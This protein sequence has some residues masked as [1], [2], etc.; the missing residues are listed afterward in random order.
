MGLYCVPFF[1]TERTAYINCYPGEQYVVPRHGEKKETSEEAEA[2][3]HPL[4]RGPRVKAV[5]TYAVHA[6]TLVG[7]ALMC[8]SILRLCPGK[9]VEDAR[10]FLYANGFHVVPDGGPATSSTWSPFSVAEKC[11]L[12]SG[13]QSELAVFRLTDGADSPHEKNH[14]FATE[15][16]EADQRRDSLVKEINKGIQKVTLSLFPV[17]EIKVAPVWG[18]V[19]TYNRI[20]AGY[21]LSLEEATVSLQYCDLCAHSQGHARLSIYD[22]EWCD[23]W[24]KYLSLT[25]RTVVSCRS[26]EHS[27]AVF[28]ID[29]NRFCARSEEEKDLWLRAVSNVKMKLQYEAPEPTDEDIAMFRAA[30]LERIGQLKEDHE[31]LDPLLPTVRRVPRPASVAGDACRP[32]P[33]PYPFGLDDL[34]PS[35]QDSGQVGHALD[36][37]P[38][39]TTRV[40]CVEI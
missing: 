2:N 23:Q 31:Q 15:G 12:K 40:K 25:D 29:G 34:S 20:M 7:G 10:L 28:S 5:P 11:P 24:V 38:T 22:D 37:Y 18:V 30:V 33:D 19:A 17:H 16:T 8:D 26:G 1:R 39:E 21:L 4:K 6:S 9:A 13:F 35:F 3:S 32:V 36:E 27:G 14:Y